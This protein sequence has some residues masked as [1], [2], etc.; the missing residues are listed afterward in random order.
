MGISFS[1]KKIYK[2]RW[3]KEAIQRL[4]LTVNVWWLPAADH[5]LKKPTCLQGQEGVTQHVGWGKNR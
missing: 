1:E 4:S 5:N 2:M 3:D